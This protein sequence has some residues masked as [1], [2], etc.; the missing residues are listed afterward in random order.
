M[1][2]AGATPR[3]LLVTGTPPG[4][5]GVGE[6]ALASLI[7]GYPA[8]HINCFALLPAGYPH[9]PKPYGSISNV[10]LRP[11]PR[12]AAW[13]PLPGKLG[14]AAARLR[15]TTRFRRAVALIAD[16]AVTLARAEH[17]D[18][19]WMVLDSVT[20]LALGTE[21]AD[22]LERPLIS[23]VWDAPEHLLRQTLQ[24]RFSTLELLRRFGE[25][26]RRSERVAVVSSEMAKEYGERY[27]AHPLVVRHPVP[28]ENARTGA[29]TTVPAVPGPGPFVIGMAGSLYADSAWE[30]LLEALHRMDW[31]MGERPIT[32]RVLGPSLRVRSWHPARI[33]YVGFQSPPE[34]DAILA[35]ADVLYLPEPFERNLREVA[36]LSFPAKLS[37]YIGAAR[38]VLVHAPE[39]SAVAAFAR[40][41]SIGMTCSTLDAAALGRVV[42]ALAEDTAAVSRASIEMRRLAE[43]EFS[44]AECR[45][46]FA[47]LV[48]GSP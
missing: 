18:K 41:H 10:W 30:A 38:P 44:R 32:L 15:F 46:R 40:S 4:D 19:V 35:N 42:R 3:L 7:A 20:T 2:G 14:S 34:R 21:V 36:R 1:G 43:G 23:L 39:D 33:E 17:I 16:E 5:N 6:T 27:G 24:D 47:E 45:R 22:R 8:G 9:H 37:T 28:D 13:N 29:D 12:E 31:R 11:R 25:T 26:L 48:A